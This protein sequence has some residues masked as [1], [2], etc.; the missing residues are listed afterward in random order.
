MFQVVS[1]FRMIGV[2][3]PRGRIVMVAF[4][5]DGQSY[6]GCLAV[7]KPVE[8]RRRVLG[9]N[10]D[11]QKAADDAGLPAA[12][13]VFHGRVQTALG[14]EAIA[15]IGSFQA[16]S[17]NAPVAVLIGQHIL[18]EQSPVGTKERPEA[19]MNQAGPETPSIIGK[20]P[21]SYSGRTKRGKRESRGANL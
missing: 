14:R 3:T 8:Q 1:D 15:L 17:N 2:K 20:Y 18:S 7:G 4:L 5:G 11:I 6:D 19:E 16:C 9:S 13:A 12:P 10:Q 21:R